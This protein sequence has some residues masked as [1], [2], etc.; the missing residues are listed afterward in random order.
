MFFL[1]GACDILT[2]NQ[3]DSKM[4]EQEARRIYEH[5][6]SLSRVFGGDVRQR[7]MEAGVPAELIDK[8]Q[9]SDAD[10]DTLIDRLDNL[11]NW[12]KQGK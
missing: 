5:K 10:I 12:M 4:S 6:L 3:G 2:K 11:D 9:R 7:C 1:F 8:F